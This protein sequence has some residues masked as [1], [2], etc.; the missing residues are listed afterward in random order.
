MTRKVPHGCPLSPR[1]FETVSLLAEGLNVK[2]IGTRMGVSRSTARSQL[3]LAYEKLGVHNGA[4]AIA[5]VIA[6]GWLEVV[7]TSWED[8]RVTAAQRLYLDAF[9]RFLLAR[10][11][12][13]RKIAR[14]DMTHHLKSMCIE[15]FIPVPKGGKRRREWLELDRLLTALSEE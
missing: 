13:D 1:Q 9:D 6:A 7:D 8:S 3:G 4:Q 2:D 10:R 11:Q 15:R 5:Q 12:V 14:L